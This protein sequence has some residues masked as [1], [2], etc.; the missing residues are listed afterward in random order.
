MYNLQP[1]E[2]QV[3]SRNF[4]EIESH[5]GKQYV[6]QDQGSIQRKM[7]VENK[8]ERNVNDKHIEEE[9]KDRYRLIPDGQNNQKHF[10]HPDVKVLTQNVASLHNAFATGE[11]SYSRTNSKNVPV[12]K[13]R[14][15]KQYYVEIVV[16]TDSSIYD[17]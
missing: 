13:I 3:S 8:E 7:S 2:A 10:L 12:D 4:M 9:L 11:N 17:L 6:L 5:L 1:S 16:L 14:N 15:L